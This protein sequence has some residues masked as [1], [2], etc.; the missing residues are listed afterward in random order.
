MALLN[1][2]I[3]TLQATINLHLLYRST[4]ILHTG[5]FDVSVIHQ[6]LTWTVGSLMCVH[7]H[8]YA[9]V[10][11]YTGWGGHNVSESAQHFRL[12]KTDNF[13]LVLLTEFEPQIIES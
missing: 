10:T 1:V 4:F 2:Q 11:T 13:F 9:C 7:D 5:S 8:S 12:G 3:I 6:T